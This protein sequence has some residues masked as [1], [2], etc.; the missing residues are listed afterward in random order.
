MHRSPV[1]VAMVSLVLC[2]VPVAGQSSAPSLSAHFGIMGGAT[3]PLSDLRTAANTGFNAGGLVEFTSTHTSLGFRLDA[4]YQRLKGK[5]EEVA[6]NDFRRTDFRFI[7][8]TANATWSVPMSNPTQLYVIGG[9][10]VYQEHARDQTNN[11]LNVSTK[12]SLNGGAGVRF[13][14]G[15]RSGF[16]EAR[17]HYIYH[18]SHINKFLLHGTPEHSLQMLPITAGFIF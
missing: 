13:P 12:L 3:V 14:I 2:A 4:Q 11:G 16:L 6:G 15:K 1:V 9:P 7:D 5:T 10:G 8:V 17:Y 18:G